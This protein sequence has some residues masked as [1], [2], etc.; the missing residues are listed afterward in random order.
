V[1]HAVNGHRDRR[2]PR[3]ALEHADLAEVL[4][5]TELPETSPGRRHSNGPARDDEQVVGQLALPEH[6]S[7]CRDLLAGGRGREPLQGQPPGPVEHP[8]PLFMNPDTVSR[9]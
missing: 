1:E 3:A 2:G 5:R 9:E 6:H 4:V 7:A 8:G